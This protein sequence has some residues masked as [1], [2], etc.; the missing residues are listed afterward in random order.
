MI[1]T[2][3]QL[4]EEQHRRL[5]QAARSQGVS[6]AE[7]VRRCNEKGI[8]TEIPDRGEQYARASRIVGK[9]RDRTDATDV[10]VNHDNYLEDAFG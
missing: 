10:S 6:V 7:I 9:F 2:Q 4:T 5:R 3:V 8:Q 1:R